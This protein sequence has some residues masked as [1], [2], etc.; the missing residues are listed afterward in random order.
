MLTRRTTFLLALTTGT[1]VANIYYAQPLLAAIAH[2]F[3]LSVPR[4]GAVAMI[5]Q[6]GAATGMFFFV[7]LGDVLERRGLICTLLLG[8]AVA[9]ILFAAAP[10]PVWLAA[11]G[12]AV[13]MAASCV[14]VVVPF[15]AHLASPEQRGR[16]VGTVL[17][18]LLLGVLLART[19]SGNL[20]AL[21]GWRAV[22]WAAAALMAV[23]AVVVR[24]GLPSS[25]PELA[26]SWPQLMHSAGALVRRHSTL[27]QAALL[28]AM[29]FFTFSAFWTTLI[30]FLQT[31]PYHYGSATAGTFGIAGAA[32][33]LG[34][35]FVGHLT[36]RH[37]PRWTIGLAILIT[38]CS[39]LVLGLLGHNLAGLILGVI[40]M[41][42]GVQSGHVANQTRI[43]NIDPKA[44]SR[45]NMVYMVTYFLGG[46]SG[47]YLGAVAW[48]SGGW[49]GVCELSA[50]VLVVAL[51]FHLT[52]PCPIPGAAQ[53]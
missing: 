11:A 48:H 47:S 50:T 41:D 5:M 44:R 31:P 13:G 35:P 6:A 45:L 2:A 20:G 25:P 29:L 23:Q 52:R 32:G 33:A 10:N 36:Q 30:F 8:C 51:L 24:F 12:F 16:S 53:A 39:F 27:R 1:V 9:L 28:G 15:A 17:G 3:S 40:M 22:F 7:P 14:H 37:G 21:I 42:L 34:A 19:F 26:M 46:A 18:G 49:T 4:A 38:L 43:Y